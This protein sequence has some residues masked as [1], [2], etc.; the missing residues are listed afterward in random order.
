[1]V[2]TAVG[3][4]R[5]SGRMLILST[6]TFPYDTIPELI[7]EGAHSKWFGFWSEDNRYVDAPSVKHWVNPGF[8]ESDAIRNSVLEYLSD[9]VALKVSSSED[10]KCKL[11]GE[12]LD[13]SFAFFTDG[14]WIWNNYLIHYVENH[15]AGLP[16]EFFTHMQAS[17]IRVVVPD[18]EDE[19][20]HIANLDWSMMPQGYASVF[21]DSGA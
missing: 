7:M 1:M 20:K 14:V 18:V 21:P 2:W 5:R 4:A 3:F 16:D 10:A 12:D 8:F 15:F 11:C 19:E 13:Q 17:Q 6:D 9:G